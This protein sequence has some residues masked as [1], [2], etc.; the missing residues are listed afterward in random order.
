MGRH[1]EPRWH[2]DNRRWYAALGRFDRRGRR[3]EVYAPVTIG[4]TQKAEAWAWFV[5]EK[6]RRGVEQR[7]EG[8]P[9]GR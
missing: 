7:T 4:L 8:H 2:K 9:D 5:A 6:E 1:A 3:R